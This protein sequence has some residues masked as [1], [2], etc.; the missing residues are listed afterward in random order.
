[1]IATLSTP[2]APKWS[3]VQLQEELRSSR[4]I[5]LRDSPGLCSFLIYRNPMPD[6]FEIIY[7]ASSK[8]FQRKGLMSQL[9]KEFLKLLQ[10][11]VPDKSE[12][13]LDVHEQN[14]AA[15]L[16]YKK[17]GFQEVGRRSNYYSDRAAAL[18]FY[19]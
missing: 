6:T 17:I 11:D 3:L 16:F 12:V 15:I 18:L 10:G 1:M 14:F 4:A 9:F 8:Q 13:W 19:Q 5:G 7:L 2:G